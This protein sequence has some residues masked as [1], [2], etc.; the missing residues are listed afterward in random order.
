MSQ[1][2]W[3]ISKMDKVQQALKAERE[4]TEKALV[5]IEKLINDLLERA[6]KGKAQ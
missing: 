1:D 2:P 4:A 6:K 5:K 3:N